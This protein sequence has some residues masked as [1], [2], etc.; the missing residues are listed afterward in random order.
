[1]PDFQDPTKLLT[2]RF[3]P[4]LSCVIS[5]PGRVNLIGEHI[6]YHDLPVLPMAIQRRIHVAFRPGED[7]R[8]RAFSHGAYG[9]REFVLNHNVQPSAPGDWENYL[10]A[11]VQ[12][13]NRIGKLT[14]GI[15]AAITSDLPPAA[16]L[17]SS[18]ALLVGITI[19]LLE[20][21]G[22]CASFEELMEVLP[23]GEHFVGTRGGGMDHAV[24]L[25]CQSGCALL[26]NFAPVKVSPIPIPDNWSFLIA[27]SLTTAEKS[28]AVRAQY[29]ARRSAGLYALQKLGFPS[30]RS[31]VETHSFDEL[32]TRGVKSSHEGILNQ[33]ELHSFL[34]VVGEA[35]RVKEAI[36]ALRDQNATAFGQLLWDSHISLRDLLRVSSSALDTLV[37]LAREAGALGARLTGA[38]FGGC[39]IV[40]CEKSSCDRIRAELVNRYY[41]RHTGFDPVSHL[42]VAQPS[43]GALFATRSSSILD[44]LNTHSGETRE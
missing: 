14:R 41:S 44:G 2:A 40:L 38:G 27:H 28:G 18:S 16:G 36:L 25:A 1:M 35:F 20:A 32:A 26:V 23:D 11:A 10:K 15:D 12:A 43:P 24:V 7:S 17:S 3:G 30:Y 8:I 19:A 34:H 4:G 37:D 5:V 42:I 13:A 39:V 21:N 22:I 9:E 29:N 33:D 6:D 31:I